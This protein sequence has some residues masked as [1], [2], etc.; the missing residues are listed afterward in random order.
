MDLS[1]INSLIELYFIKSEEVDGKKP[2]LKRLKPNKQTY[3]WQ[4]ITER[5]YKLSYKIK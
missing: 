1:K 5:I 3:N 2:F 4:D